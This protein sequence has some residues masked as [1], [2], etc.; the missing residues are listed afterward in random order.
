MPLA[1][2]ES[3]SPPQSPPAAARETLAAYARWAALYDPIIGPICA[4]GRRAAAR[5]AGRCGRRILEIGVG[6][7]L[8]FADYRPGTEVVGI[9]VSAEMIAVARHKAASG[10]FPQVRALLLMDAHNLDL[11]ADD[12]DAVAVP[13]AITLMTSPER[14]LDECARVVRPGGEIVLVSHFGAEDGAAADLGRHLTRIGRAAGLCF[15]FPFSRLKRWAAA[16]PDI[17]LAERRRLAPFGVYTLARFRRTAASPAR[18]P[19]APPK[20]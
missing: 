17:E 19:A 11:P 3:N 2:P 14:V 13:F 9:D 18:A 4:T 1:S 16:R 15:D 20:G 7:G 12:F 10:R 8:T 6:T 5:A